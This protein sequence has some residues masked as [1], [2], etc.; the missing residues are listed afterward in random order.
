MKKKAS[1]SKKNV[2]KHLK[3]DKKEYREMIKDDVKLE[4]SLKKR[5]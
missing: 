1:E 3:E 5:K 4:K 2:L